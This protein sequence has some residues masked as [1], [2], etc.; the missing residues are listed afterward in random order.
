MFFFFVCRE[1]AVPKSHVVFLVLRISKKN[2][3]TPNRGHQNSFFQMAKTVTRGSIEAGEGRCFKH[4]GLLWSC[5]YRSG[6]NSVFFFC[7]ENFDDDRDRLRLWLDFFLRLWNY[8]FKIYIVWIDRYIPTEYH[9]VIYPHISSLF[10][11]TYF[12]L[13][14][15]YIC[16]KDRYLDQ[17]IMIC[18][19]KHTSL[20]QFF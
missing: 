2:Q 8:P 4:C 16:K 18:I 11:S 20:S 5:S 15:A 3:P 17:S 6:E 7:G 10:A 9:I 14:F 12:F 1:V 13:S 19:C